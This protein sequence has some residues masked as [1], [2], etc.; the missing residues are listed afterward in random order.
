[1]ENEWGIDSMKIQG[2]FVD[3]HCF[4]EDVVHRRGLSPKDSLDAQQCSERAGTS[5]PRKTIVRPGF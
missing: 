2:Y 5:L 4:L 3:E 1:L